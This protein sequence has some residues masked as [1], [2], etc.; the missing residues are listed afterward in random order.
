MQTVTSRD[1][2]PIAYEV[3]GGGPA[4]VL[5]GTTASD[6]PCPRRPGLAELLP[7][8]RYHPLPGQDHSAFWVAT[9]AV[10]SSI[11]RFLHASAR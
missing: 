1:G 7:N 2:T 3:A 6:H 9:E 5:V 4:V 10:A 11:T 8:T